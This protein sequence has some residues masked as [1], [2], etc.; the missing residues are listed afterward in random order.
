MGTNETK[1]SLTPSVEE[2]ST[3]KR[4]KGEGGKRVCATQETYLPP[5]CGGPFT[6]RGSRAPLSP[7]VGR[8]CQAYDSIH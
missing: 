2:A 4:L 8:G 5:A 7:T 3:A 1:E 6:R